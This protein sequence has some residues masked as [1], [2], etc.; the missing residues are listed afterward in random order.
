MDGD[1]GSA[2]RSKTGGGRGA[3]WAVALTV[4]AVAALVWMLAAIRVPV[5]FRNLRNKLLTR[6]FTERGKLVSA[7]VDVF[8]RDTGRYPTALDELTASTGPS[9]YRGPY[10]ETIP[11]NP[12]RES[13]GWDYDPTTGAVSDPGGKWVESSALAGVTASESYLDDGRMPEI[14]GTDLRT[15]E[16]VRVALVPSRTNVVY[17]GSDAAPTFRDDMA[18]LASRGGDPRT[19]VAVIVRSRWPS[20]DMRSREVA[21]LRVPFTVI[22][23]TAHARE[24]EDALNVTRPPATFLCDGH[25]RR[26]ARIDGKVTEEYL[27]AAAEGVRNLRET[28]ALGG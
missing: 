12:G 17:I 1:D 19:V 16:E 8:H 6:E 4:V 3:W 15:G 7:A 21:A 27:R 13:A 26:R 5:E 10:L 22:D 18:A 14:V 9:G 25:G 2:T 23:A 11:A 24:I 20:V 28:I